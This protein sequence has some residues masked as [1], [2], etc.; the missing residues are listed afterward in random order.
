MIENLCFNFDYDR[1]A[2]SKIRRSLKNSITSALEALGYGVVRDKKLQYPRFDEQSGRV[3]RMEKGT[4]DILCF[5]GKRQIAVE[6][7]RS[8]VVRLKTVMKLLASDAQ[9]RIVVLY[10]Q[11]IRTV[12]RE[13]ISERIGEV[14]REQNVTVPLIVFDLLEKRRYVF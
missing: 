4:L 13:W 8:S 14:K 11:R 5:R 7:N 12:Q 9:L 3:G 6:V 1:I 10:P 2:D